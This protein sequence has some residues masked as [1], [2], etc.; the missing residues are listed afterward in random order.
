MRSPVGKVTDA[1]VQ[2]DRTPVRSLIEKYADDIETDFLE[3]AQV[4]DSETSNKGE[5]ICKAEKY[6]MLRLLFLPLRLF[7]YFQH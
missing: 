6:K 4:N 1:D 5:C 2:T 7:F 3:P